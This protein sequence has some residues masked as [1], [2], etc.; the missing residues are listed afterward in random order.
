M[1]ERQSTIRNIAIIAHVD[2]GKT[3]LVD[4]LL[5]Q[6]NTFRDADAQGTTILDSNELERE[7]GITIF[8]KNA[9]IEWKGVK[10]NIVDTPGHADFGGEVERIM[11]L[12]DACLLLVD[13]KEGPMPQTKFVL[14]K[15]IDA[16]HKIILVI[17]KVDRKDAR[18][19]W[20]LN[21]TF[22]LF[23][24]LG[25]SD[26]QANFPVLYAS[27]LH[28]VAGT[29][30]DMASMKSIIPIFDCI[31]AEAPAPKGDRE[32][33]LQI[34]VVNV[35]Y[36]N[37]KGKVGIGRV[38]NGHVEDGER[39]VHINREGTIVPAKITGLMTFK[40]LDKVQVSQAAAG[41][42]VVVAGIDDITIGET[43]AD[44][45]HP[46]ALPPLS[47]EEPTV[48]MTFGVN[49]SPLAGTEA[50]YSTSRNLEE[51]LDRE[52]QNDVAL[53]VERGTGEGAFV[54]SGRGELHLAILIE[55]MRRESYELQVS[56]PQVIFKEVDGKQQEPF[57]LVSIEA[58]EK[59]SG[60][61]IEKMGKRKG[62]MKDMRV[63]HGTAYMDFEIPTRGL[64]GYRNEF[65]TDTKGQGIINSLL[66][67]YRPKIGDLA[68]A[69]H[70]SLIA[71]EAG[72]SMGYSLANLQERGVLFIGPTVDV[73]VGMVIGANARAEDMEV[74]PCKAKKM[75]NMRS[76]GDGASVQLEKPRDM[77]LE[78]AL[79]YI[80]D[81]ELVEV[82]PKSIRIRKAILDTHSRRR[83]AAQD[84]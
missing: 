60:I 20:V 51:R 84:L 6:S 73:Y 75:S 44:A 27:A 53:R 38:M 56:R 65:I 29:E 71:M 22:D 14:K 37:Y 58:P 19:E 23:V 46:I 43:I 33:P 68:T 2:H 52:L 76:K 9:A 18:P 39:V 28:G 8:S 55:K 21:H 31:I 11:N 81:D 41:E 10:I 17:N 59:S 80:G 72:T 54:V 50:T 32:K 1:D 30:H 45:E 15:A 70:G 78:N 4:A 16:G 35:Q 61:I 40:G 5:K 49:T 63:E 25:A 82:T 57:E 47:I 26:S 12:V 79:E 66:L 48:K 69:A 3:T 7:R 74:N 67:G 62:E 34:S 13:A 42:I 24:E 83:A 36:D 64:I 77:Q